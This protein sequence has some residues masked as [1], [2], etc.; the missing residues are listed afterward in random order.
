ML[1]EICANSYQSAINAQ[2]ARAHRIELCQTLSVGGLTPSH[3]LITQVV[4]AL[5][6]PVFVLI[7]PRAGNFVYSNA[8]F[9]VMKE[10]I[11][12]CKAIG[13]SG[14][15]SGVLHDDHTIDLERTKALMVLSRPLS[16]TF[17]RAFDEVINPELALTQLIDLGVDRIL[18]SGQQSNAEAGIE[19]LTDLNKIANNKIIIMPGAG[20]NANNA[21]LFKTSGF[22][23]LHASASSPIQETKEPIH[24]DHTVSDPQ[25][26]EAILN[27]ISDEI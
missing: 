22:M 23:E 8:E 7:R 5:R 12:T 10:D 26:I 17:H 3:E 20:I 14:I 9:E 11:K 21:Y 16:F 15:V 6:I 27:V 19:L 25:K 18:T 4:N 24:G 2:D 1:L 13:V